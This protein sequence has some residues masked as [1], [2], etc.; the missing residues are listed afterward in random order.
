VT[1][2]SPESPTAQGNG[3]AAQ[4]RVQALQQRALHAGLALR[5]PPPLP[6]SCCGRG[7]NGCVW[8]GYFRALDYWCE[9]AAQA[10][11]LI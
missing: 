5:A 11:L 3:D 10:M 2:E 9:E 8:E 6:I 4:L 1:P 7:C